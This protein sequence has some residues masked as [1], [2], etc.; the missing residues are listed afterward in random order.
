MHETRFRAA[1]PWFRDEVKNYKL[2]LSA[3]PLEAL[4]TLFIYDLRRE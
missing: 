3:L 2:S 4:N 1:Q